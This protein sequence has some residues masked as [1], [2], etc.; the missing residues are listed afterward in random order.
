MMVLSLFP[1]NFG[2]LVLG[3]T[4]FVHILKLG[5]GFPTQFLILWSFIFGNSSKVKHLRK[6]LGLL[7]FKMKS[8]KMRI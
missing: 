3:C 1:L 7:C 6:L 5:I 2:L 8:R 4:C